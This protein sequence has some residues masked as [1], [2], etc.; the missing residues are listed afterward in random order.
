MRKKAHI[1]NRP[2]T[3]TF[4]GKRGNGYSIEYAQQQ[5]RNYGLLSMGGWCRKCIKE[6]K[7]TVK[8]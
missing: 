3:K 5:D 6:F 1:M 2:W 7:K 4:C 8:V